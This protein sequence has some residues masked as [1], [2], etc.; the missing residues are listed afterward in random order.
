MSPS[1]S[2]GRSVPLADPPPRSMLH[3]EVGDKGLQSYNAR[4]V[5]STR[6]DLSV[7]EGVSEV[8]PTAARIALGR[9][10]VTGSGHARCSAGTGWQGAA[11]LLEL[12]PG[13]HLLGVDRGLDA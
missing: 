8:E 10:G 1:C 12:G 4:R 11:H 6:R 3:P 2:G 13:G 9:G 7:S 5:R